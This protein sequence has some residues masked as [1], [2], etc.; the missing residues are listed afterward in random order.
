MVEKVF[1]C[2]WSMLLGPC[3]RVRG[4]LGKS[5]DSATAF[6][7]EPSASPDPLLGVERGKHYGLMMDIGGVA[8][9]GGCGLGAQ[10]AVASVEV[11]GADVVGAVGAGE[12]HASLNARD[13]VKALHNASVVL[14][15]RRERHGGGAAKVTKGQFQS[16][17][18]GLGDRGR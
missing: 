8:I 12:L 5:T 1:P 4:L 14:W 7:R 17:N 16:G 10:V 13:G 9:D 2:Y 15:R 11:K 18:E 3:I 6:V